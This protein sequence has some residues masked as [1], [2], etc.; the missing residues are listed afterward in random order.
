[1]CAKCKNQRVDHLVERVG[2]Q[3]GE[4][5]RDD[6]EAAALELDAVDVD[7]DRQQ[8]DRVPLE[9]VRVADLFERFQRERGRRSK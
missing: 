3:H 7:S 6:V 8:R 2:E 5:C 1:V 9:V 4:S